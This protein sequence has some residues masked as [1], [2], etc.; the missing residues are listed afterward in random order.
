[1]IIA[2]ASVWRAALDPTTLDVCA[3][4]ADLWARREL[5][6]PTAV[7]AQ[8][9]SET[10]V[11]TDIAQIRSWA[12]TVTTVTTPNEAWLAAGDLAAKLRDAGDL[13]NIIDVLVLVTAVREGAPVWTLSRPVTLALN[14]LPI[15]AWQADQRR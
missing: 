7:F 3:R 8:L 15:Q 6:S 1:M 11:A 13:L 12:T 9:L 5:T 2:D 14:T 10:D 4:V